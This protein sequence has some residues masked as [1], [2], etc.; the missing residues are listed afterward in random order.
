MPVVERGDMGALV[1][2]AREAGDDDIAGLA[3][4]AR[5]PIGEGQARRRGVARADDRDRG[6]LQ[7][8]LA[9]AQ[10][11]QRRRANRSA[12][13][14]GGYSGSPSATKRTPSLP[15]ERE[16]ALDLFALGDADRPRRAAA[17]RQVRQRVER[18]AGGA[19]L[20]ISARKV[21]GPTFSER[22]SR[23][24]SNRSSS[25]EADAAGVFA[26]GSALPR[27]SSFPFPASRRPMLALC[28]IH[29][30]AASAPKTTATALSPIASAASGAARLAASAAAEE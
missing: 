14:A 16:F 18:R 29:S 15:R 19:E 21:R 22:M 23:S 8:L 7:R 28:L 20:S 25:V 3:E 17:A 2:A 12:R 13:S 27:R 9:A 1:D 30:S 26:H 11:E 24:Q 4:A 5:Q 6:L 10:R